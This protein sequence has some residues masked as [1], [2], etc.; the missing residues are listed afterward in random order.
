[1]FQTKGIALQTKDLH[2]SMVTTAHVSNGAETVIG[3]NESFA[4]LTKMLSHHHAKETISAPTTAVTI[5][6][7]NNEDPTTVTVGVSILT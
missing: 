3:N 1:M 6:E 4:K 2:V 5:P 7:L